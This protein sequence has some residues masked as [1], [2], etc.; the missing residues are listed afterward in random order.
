MKTGTRD[1]PPNQTKF[2]PD[3]EK[4]AQYESVYQ[5]Y[6]KLVAAHQQI[7]KALN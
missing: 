1:A 6:K 5:R 4:V 2:E 7:D 3:A